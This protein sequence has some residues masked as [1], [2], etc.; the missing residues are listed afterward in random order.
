MTALSE[1][2]SLWSSMPRGQY[3]D[4]IRS[5]DYNTLTVIR[6]DDYHDQRESSSERFFFTLLSFQLV[7]MCVRSARKQI[8]F[9]I[10]IAV[11][12]ESREHSCEE[13]ARI[14]LR[15]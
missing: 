2:D 8:K 12:N 5:T 15:M 4:L 1:L 10:Q 9:Q 13:K 11:G 6:H 3:I 14:F 7:Q